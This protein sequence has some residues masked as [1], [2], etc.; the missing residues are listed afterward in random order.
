MENLEL[1]DA[2]FKMLVDGLAMLPFKRNS[3]SSLYDMLIN[4]IDL[5]ET[6]EEKRKREQAVKVQ[7][8]KDAADLETLIEDVRVLQGKLITYKRYMAEQN[9]L[10]KTN[11]IINDAK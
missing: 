5:H 9:G 7:R 10:N 11:K 2:E 8:E 1:T 3:G 6:P 4:V